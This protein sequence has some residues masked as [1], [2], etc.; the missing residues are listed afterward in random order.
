MVANSAQCTLFD[1]VVFVFLFGGAVCVFVNVFSRLCCVWGSQLRFH[2][3]LFVL[4]Y[5]MCVG[6]CVS[7]CVHLGTE[8]QY[9]YKYIG[10]AQTYYSYSFFIYVFVFALIWFG[11]RVCVCLCV[12]VLHRCFSL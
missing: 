7:V 12:F 5:R 10:L 4:V 2:H 11:M 1:F 9:K 3:Q 8:G 6:V